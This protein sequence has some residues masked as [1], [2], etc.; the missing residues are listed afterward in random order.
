[1]EIAQQDIVSFEGAIFGFESYKKFVFLFQE[2]ISEHFV[3][4]QSVEEPDLCFILVEPGLVAENYSPALPADVEEL[5][6][7]GEYMC[8]LMTV[9]K[10]DF[11]NSTV[12]LRSP[13][14][15]NSTTKKAA[16]VILEGDYPIRHPLLNQKEGA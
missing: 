10:E 14:V 3:W 11:H 9:I 13:I 1:M 5:L 7:G 6:G 16:Q 12:N 15:V 8:L 2:D 4:L